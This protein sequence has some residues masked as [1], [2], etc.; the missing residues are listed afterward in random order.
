MS[1]AAQTVAN[2]Q[3]AQSSTGPRT[4][5]GKHSSSH[6]AATHG[7][8]GRKLVLNSEEQAEYD[9]L[10]AKLVRIWEP[11]EF[12]RD[13]LEEYAEAKWRLR[14]CR[15]AETAFHDRCIRELMEADPSL[16]PDEALAMIFTE[17]VYMA[18][19][20]LFL[21]YQSAIE[22]ALA[23]AERAFHE[24][25]FARLEVRNAELEK[26][27]AEAA[28]EVAVKRYLDQHPNGFV[29]QSVAAGSQPQPNSI[30]ICANPDNG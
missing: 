7:L 15:R 30:G 17:P 14:R 4:P 11:G 10:V 13:F 2:R 12:E 1:S 23:K 6:N 25:M 3:N 8:T 18:K 28:A 24:A 16:S 27:Q 20:R 21:R 22:R 9:A 19:M 5:E 29:S 26:L